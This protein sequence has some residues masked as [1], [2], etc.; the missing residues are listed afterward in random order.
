[1]KRV[2]LEDGTI[3]QMDYRGDTAEEKATNAV[4]VAVLGMIVWNMEK[5]GNLMPQT[6]ETL[7][8]CI[9]D[10]LIIT[11]ENQPAQAAPPGEPLVAGAE[12]K[13]RPRMPPV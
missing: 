4:D 11:P 5:A 9:Q 12:R 13:T 3:A 10:R 6:E 8:R 1:M 2:R 7:N